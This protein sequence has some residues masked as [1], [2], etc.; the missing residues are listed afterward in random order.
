MMGG[1]VSGMAISVRLRC[2]RVRQCWQCSAGGWGWW[3]VFL[4]VS[5][6]REKVNGGEEFM[7]EGLSAIA[8]GSEVT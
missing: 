1:Y 4:E 8:R 6:T 3:S 5:T 2:L 7:Q